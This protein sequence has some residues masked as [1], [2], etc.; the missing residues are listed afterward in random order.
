MIRAIDDAGDAL[1]FG[2]GRTEPER[3]TMSL[4]HLPRPYRV[5]FAKSE[6]GVHSAS[7]VSW[8]G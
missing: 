6:L 7:G 4:D 5:N 8:T 3:W 2:T 1:I